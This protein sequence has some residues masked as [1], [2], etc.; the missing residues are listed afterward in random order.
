MVDKVYI[1]TAGSYSDYRIDRVYLDEDE[2]WAYVNAMGK[3]WP[4]DNAD[5]QEWVVG[6]PAVEFDGPIWEGEFR[7]SRVVKTHGDFGQVY[8]P[9]WRDLSDPRYTGEVEDSYNYREI[10]WTGE[11]PPKAKVHHTDLGAYRG[12]TIYACVRG[13]SRGHVEKSLQDTVARLKAEKA[14]IA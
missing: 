3:T 5:V 11:Q 8:G 14:G 4:V 9:G 7:Q 10:W 13:L 1:V 2:A 12:G 6:A